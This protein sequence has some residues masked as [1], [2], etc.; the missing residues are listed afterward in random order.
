MWKLRTILK[1]RCPAMELRKRHHL[2]LGVPSASMRPAW[3]AELGWVRQNG[4]DIC[5]LTTSVAKGRALPCQPPSCPQ[6]GSLSTGR[7]HSWVPCM[8]PG[9]EQCTGTAVGQTLNPSDSAALTWGEAL[10]PR[11]GR[12]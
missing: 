6:C 10:P 2:L 4:L 7:R 12:R 5:R 11:E 3:F 1:K 8:V 9:S